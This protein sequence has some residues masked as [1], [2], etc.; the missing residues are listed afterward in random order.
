[1]SECTIVILAAGIG[2]RYGGL[3]QADPVGPHGQLIIHYSVYDALRA[4]FSKVV[5]VIRHEI[6]EVF[7]DR[8]GRAV[9]RQIDVSYVF[10][11]V[12]NLPDGFSVPAGRKKPWG[13]GHAVLCCKDAAP[14]NFAVINADD[15][16][17]ATSYATLARFLSSAQDT[18][19][20]YHYAMMGYVLSN[21]LSE[22]GAVA[23]GICQVG[24]AGY[25]ESVRE[26]RHIIQT[27][28]GPQFKDESGSFHPL[29]PDC[30]VSMNMWGFT[31]SFFGELETRFQGFLA[32]DA[33]VEPLTSEFLLPDVVNSLVEQE[34]ACVKVLPTAEKWF[35]V[36]YQGDR[37]MVRA[38]IEGLVASGQYP[39]SLWGADEL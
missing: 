16:Y 21:T 11:E 34:K 8:V 31:P 38:A 19:E 4:G 22:H 30:L 5:F 18:A 37:P 9:E 26:R 35:G 17:G 23:R 28:D 27:A 15:F 10:Q 24:P 39:A 12:Q 13:T 33:V 2:S 1:M 6:E 32:R 25:L 29:P 7:R 20:G 36:T 14:G 3:K